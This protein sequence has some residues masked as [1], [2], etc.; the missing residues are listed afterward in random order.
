[1]CMS[2]RFDLSDIKRTLRYMKR[3]G[4]SNAYYAA[5]ER[6]KLRASSRYSYISPGEGE[7]ANQCNE[8]RA[9]EGAPSIT[10]V[11]PAYE[12][13]ENYFRKAV[14]SV[15]SQSYPHWRLVIT[16][17]SSSDG[18]CEIYKDLYADDPRIIYVKHKGASGISANTDTGIDKA[19]GTGCDYIGFLDHDD[20]L[21]PDALYHMAMAAM[22]HKSD[23]GYP[24]LVYSDEDKMNEPSPGT[25]V[26]F[27]PHRKYDFNFDL[28][29]SNN[30][31]C[32]FMIV[33]SDIMSGIRFRSEY[34]GEQDY[35]LVLRIAEQI[36]GDR[37]SHTGSPDWSRSVV[38]VPRVLYHWRSHTGSTA[39]NT[40]SKRYAYEAGLHAVTEL[41]NEFFSNPDVPGL[42]TVSHSKHLGFYDVNWGDNDTLFALRP[43]VGAVIGRVLDKHGVMKEC[44]YDRDGHAL[45]AGLNKNFA[46][47]FN[48]FDCTQEVYSADINHVIVRPE[49]TDLLKEARDNADLA[50]KLHDMGYIILYRP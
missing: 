12:P 24:A 48:R 29:L 7:L 39:T 28:L 30:Y 9:L 40:E 15:I 37:A 26:Y 18:V 21:T 6:L 42:P 10:V 31:V 47:E 34:E 11:I 49:L 2:K 22:E 1:M 43:D 36:M 4:V 41:V 8:T 13:D 16:D 3:N 23:S 46:G 50:S 35:D 38:H 33:R 19:L 17:S 44:I 32:H 20:V 14:E 25:V 27:D 5:K 45:Y